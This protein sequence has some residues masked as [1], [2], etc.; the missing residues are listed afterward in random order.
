MKNKI[1]WIMAVSL[2][3]SLFAFQPVTAC[4]KYANT[5]H[6]L[7]AQVNDTNPPS[8]PMVSLGKISRG[9]GP[10]TNGV[11]C[12]QTVS[13]CDDLGSIQLM[14]TAT[15]D[16]TQPSQ[17][18][19]MI[20][21]LGGNLPAGLLLPPTAVRARIDGSLNL[22]WID[23]ASDDQESL[24]FTLEVRAVDLAGNTSPATSVP[25][26]QTGSG[27]GCSLL[28][29][30]TLSHWSIATLGILLLT[31]AFRVTRRRRGDLPLC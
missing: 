18:G 29:S 13:S 19:Y 21:L 3:S 7:D 15:D 28:A 11:G 17:M 23:G 5:P 25:I 12:T 24:S 31:H 22:G 4:E 6:V 9:K 8:A 26:H 10:E 14:V 2:A 16:Q 27:D 30:R 20:T 1:T